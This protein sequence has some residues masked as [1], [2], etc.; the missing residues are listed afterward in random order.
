MNYADYLKATN[1]CIE[2]VDEKTIEDFVTSLRS[3]K[4][5][6]GRVFFLGVGG[7]AAN[8]SHAVNDFRKIGGLDALTPL[9]NVAELTAYVND[10]SFEDSLV[11]SLRTSDLKEKDAIV[12]FSVGGG[13]ET[14][15]KNIVKAIDY[16]S[17]VDAL[18]LGIVSRD[19]GYTKQKAH[20]C[21]HFC[22]NDSTMITPVAESL[23]AV[24]WHYIVN[25]I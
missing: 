13:S 15:S 4:T 14:T 12:I 24:F 21:I 6:G 17:E 16:A 10:V 5:K 9:D 8:C 7:S 2:Q 18:I 3:V 19:G 22:P 1:E 11:S 23:Q 25:K 20:V